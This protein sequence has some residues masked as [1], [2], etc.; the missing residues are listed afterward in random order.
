LIE[1]YYDRIEELEDLNTINVFE[2]WKYNIATDNEAKA[3]FN[4][5]LAKN[6]A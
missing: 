1:M 3:V 6:Y 4:K 5:L 2:N